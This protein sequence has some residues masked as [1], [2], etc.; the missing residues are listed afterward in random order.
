MA[1]RKIIGNLAVLGFLSIH[2]TDEHGAEAGGGGEAVSDVFPLLLLPHLTLNH[3]NSKG[4]VDHRSE[5]RMIVC[6]DPVNINHP[7]T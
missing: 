3:N 4:D 6:S 5:D 2:S 1:S 7:P